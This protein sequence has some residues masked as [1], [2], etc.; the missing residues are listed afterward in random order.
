MGDATGGK[1]D[2]ETGA[3]REESTMLPKNNYRDGGGH[4]GDR[5]TAFLPFPPLTQPSADLVNV[6]ALKNSVKISKI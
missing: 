3:G 1:K 2:G 4:A 6:S 5:P